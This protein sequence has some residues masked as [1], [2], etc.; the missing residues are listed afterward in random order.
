VK[1]RERLVW[2]DALR[3]ATVISMVLYHGMW[4]AVYL[5][6]FSAPWYGALPGYLWQQSICWSFL[7]LSGWCFLYDRK[8]LKRGMTVFLWGAAISLVTLLAMPEERILF[9]VLTLIGSSILLTIPLDRLVRGA[10]GAHAAGSGKTGAGAAD[11]GSSEGGMPGAG[12]TGAGIADIGRAG[13]ALAALLFFITR[14]VNR[15]TLGFERLS[16]CPLPVGLYRNL[17]T[18][19]LG[20][21]PADFWSTDYFSLIP[22]YFLYLTGYFLHLSMRQKTVAPGQETPPVLIRALCAVGRRAFLIYLLHQ[23]LLFL[24]GS[25][26]QRMVK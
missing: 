22:W 19:Y 11:A 20:F 26:L 18:A 7:L 1:G 13:A 10:A 9:G 5:W 15:G 23:P 3:G 4:D 17:F 21:P 16:F 14:N 24:I 6:G 25:A 8:P 2:P 12:G